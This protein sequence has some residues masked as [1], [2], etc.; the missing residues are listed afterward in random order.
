MGYH[1][2]WPHLHNFRDTDF[3]KCDEQISTSSEEKK[4]MRVQGRRGGMSVSAQDYSVRYNLASR[5]QKKVRVF[6]LR[7]GKCGGGW[8]KFRRRTG[9][10][11]LT[12]FAK[13]RSK[14]SEEG[15]GG[16]KGAEIGG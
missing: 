10:G 7:L 1:P 13:P 5:N 14:G 12:N 3:D 4:S 9:D 6:L 2:A 11:Y 15:G 16:R 8:V